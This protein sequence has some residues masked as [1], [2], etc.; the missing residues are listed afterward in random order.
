MNQQEVLGTNPVT[1]PRQNNGG[2]PRLLEVDA[3]K[4]RGLPWGYRKVK[5][6]CPVECHWTES[7]TRRGERRAG[8]ALSAGNKSCHEVG[9]KNDISIGNSTRTSAWTQWLRAAWT[10]SRS[11]WWRATRQQCSTSI[12]CC[13]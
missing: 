8:G 5:W 12:S 3:R 1:I 2:N 6:R 13:H 10:G 11:H 9:V 7:D 4:V